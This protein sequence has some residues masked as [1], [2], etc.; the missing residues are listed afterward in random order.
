[1]S[2]ETKQKPEEKPAKPAAPE[3]PAKP[4]TSAA[5]FK[6]KTSPKPKK[7]EEFTKGAPK[8]KGD[9]EVVLKFKGN[10]EVL[11]GYDPSKY[12]GREIIKHRGIT[13]RRS[14]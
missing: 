10:V 12:E 13:G 5:D 11:K 1:M 4:A 8:K 9:Y 14:K 2:E 7:S 6:P 3:T